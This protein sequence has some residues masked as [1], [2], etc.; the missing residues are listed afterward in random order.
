MNGDTQDDKLTESHVQDLIPAAV[1]IPLLIDESST[2]GS[3]KSDP[4]RLRTRKGIIELPSHTEVVLTVRTHKVEHHK[5]QI[6]F[7]GG[8]FEPDDRDLEETALRESHE[9]IGLHRDHVEIVA[10]LPDVPTVASRF[11][12]RPYVGIVRSRPQ[13]QPN[14]D[15]IGQILIVPL[16][17]L[18]HPEHS[19]LETF[20]RGN[21]RVQ[22][23]TY[24]YDSHRIWGATGLML[25]MFLE[26]FLS[27]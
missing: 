8:C 18:L 26:K 1:L 16:H 14:P 27:R 5:G 2:N 12:V 25:Q 13:F 11:T 24:Y 6:A 20:E 22:M 3:P 9:E 21:L 4:Y 7:P 15:E 10:E 23:R 19:V 17:H